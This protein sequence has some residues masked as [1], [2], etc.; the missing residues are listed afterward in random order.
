MDSQLN[1]PHEGYLTPLWVKKH[2]SISN[3]TLYSWIA[4]RRLA[5]PLRLGKRAVRFR[6]EDIR[7]F[8]AGLL[9]TDQ[10][11]STRK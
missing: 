7:R 10:N 5:A 9:A 8:E 4:E 2:F 1:I 3:S 11:A 6:A